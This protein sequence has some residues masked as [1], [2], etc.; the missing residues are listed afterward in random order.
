MPGK[1]S[2]SELQREK[3]RKEELLFGKLNLRERF[4]KGLGF[5]MDLLQRRGLGRED[6]SQCDK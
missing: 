1:V 3:Q 4:M 6:S 5:S 2:P